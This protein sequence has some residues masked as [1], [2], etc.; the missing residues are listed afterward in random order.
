MITEY[1]SRVEL[2]TLT[3]AMRA[4]R[5]ANWLGEK[6]VPHRLDG[7]RVIVSRLHVQAWLEGRVAVKSSG[8]NWAAIR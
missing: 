1:L 2:A 4:G 7:Q 3:G 8:P 5:Q 6:G